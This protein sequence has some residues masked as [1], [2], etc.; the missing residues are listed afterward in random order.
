MSS[1]LLT[2]VMQHDDKNVQK[3]TATM[4]NSSTNALL[5]VIDDFLPL[6]LMETNLRYGNFHLVKMGLF[7]R[8]YAQE[9]YFS[10]PT[11]FLLIRLLSLEMLNRQWMPVQAKLLGRGSYEDAPCTLE[12]MFHALEH[13]NVHNAL[14]YGV[15]LLKNQPEACLHSLFLTGAA[16]IPDTLGHSISCFFPVAED[17]LFT[18][19]KDTNTALL[20]YLMYV[21]R[22][23]I[24]PK[25]WQEV[26]AQSKP[27][28]QLETPSDLLK[29]A[30]SGAGIV[31]LHH[32]IT[33]YILTA[34]EEAAFNPERRVPYFLLIDWMAGKEIDQEREIA[35]AEM[36]P[37]P[38]LPEDYEA[39]EKRFSL[40]H[41]DDT[42][43]S[44]FALLD[45]FPDRTIDWLFR[46]YASLYDPETW[47]PH[48]YTSLYAALQLY[49]GEQLSDKVACRMAVDQALRY[50]ADGL[51][52]PQ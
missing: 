15:R 24:S 21:S 49:L 36:S 27:L 25:T 50:F 37:P 16:S 38:K 1:R 11:I 35:V 26:K 40:E 19:H 10:R 13:H 14:Y 2:T 39:F 17:L 41:L 33:F 6:M 43:A 20:S 28:T 5:T 31:N 23:D 45:Q 32:M 4:K 34:W 9:Q 48:Y 3:I 30:A 8:K 52:S 12:E 44:V 47:N 51:A 22:F 42:L 29:R 46:K 18:P 7:L